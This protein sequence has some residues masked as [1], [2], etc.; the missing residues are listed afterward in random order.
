IAA[1]FL[2]GLIVIFTLT[3][4]AGLWL[5]PLIGPR[6][7]G[8]RLEGGAMRFT[9]SGDL[10]VSGAA[11]IIEPPPGS[12]LKGDATRLLSIDRMRIGLSLLAPFTGKDFIYEVAVSDADILIAKPID[13]YDIN[14]L[15]I[16]DAGPP[17]GGPIKAP[18]VSIRRATL[19]LAE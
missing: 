12:H 17:T 1:A 2:I 13:G 8:M 5:R 10:I 7:S 18:G 11:I 14:L 6:L 16:F 3:P 19:T 4:L 9:A 15:E